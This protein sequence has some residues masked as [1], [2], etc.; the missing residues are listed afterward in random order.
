MNAAKDEPR[1]PTSSYGA[2]PGPI[3]ARL[4]DILAAHQQWVQTG[5]KEGKRADLAEATL[6]RASLRLVVLSDANLQG[7]DLERAVL[8]SAR[9]QGANL[10]GANL[11]GA[12]LQL[13]ALHRANMQGADLFEANLES[14]NLS[15][16]TLQGANLYF[17]NLRGS[18]LQR[19]SL[20]R[21]WLKEAILQEA[22]LSGANL[23]GA[24]LQGADLRGADLRRANLREANLVEADLQG[25]DLQGADLQ[26]GNLQ[27]ASLHYANVRDA[28]L[29]STAG[30]VGAQLA[31]TFLAGARLPTALS[32]FTGLTHVTVLIKQARKLLTFLVLGCAFSWL[33][34]ASAT[35]ARLLTNAPAALLA[36]LTVP[37]PSA[38]FFHVMPLL[39]LGLFVYFHLH[40][41]RLW[42]ELAEL[43]A[44]F[45]DGRPLDRTA[46]P[47]LL[48]GLVRSHVR[49]LQTLRPPLSRLQSSLAIVLA[50]WLVPALLLLF[51]IRYLPCQDWVVTTWH[52]T[53]LVTA[54]GFAM[55]FQGLARTMLRGRTIR[56]FQHGAV[57]L[58]FAFACHVVFS[59]LS[60][61]ALTGMPPHLPLAGQTQSQ[62]DAAPTIHALR[63][64]VPRLLKLIDVSPFATLAEVDVSTKLAPLAADG[65]GSLNQ[66]KGANLLGRNLRYANAT[67]AFLAKA[68]LRQADLSGADLRRADLRGA[69]FEGAELLGTHLQGA[70]LSFA[71]GLT[72][73][74]LTRARLDTTTRL[75][76]E[77]NVPLPASPAVR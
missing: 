49:R 5:G 32:A 15:E 20:Q 56:R 36:H 8:A 22:N 27:D 54:I 41:H 18:D 58:L 25:A 7:A 45:P 65:E 40:L 72:R 38:T 16:A 69:R 59:L 55:L 74:Q 23:S 2:T 43:P 66:V 11:R 26:G 39:L 6:G 24:N 60:F 63:Q 76:A 61:G 67:G 70:D 33:I 12:D 44:V 73:E 14:A 62:T 19:V 71:T 48:L 3:T 13:A 28:D 75:P 1:E 34:I 37:L 31:G 52:I 17:A 53:L 57:A 9:L 68:D 64:L 29:T 21:A 50:W 30:L 51:W 77:L 35:D 4:P 47:W 10:Q 42:E 46:Y